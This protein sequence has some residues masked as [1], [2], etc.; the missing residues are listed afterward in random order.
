[1]SR[2]PEESLTPKQHKA[3]YALLE[4][5]TLEAAAEDVGVSTATIKRW[6]KTEAF[7]SEFRRA[8]RR[9]L[10]D[11]YAK[12]Q[13]AASEAVDTLVAHM[14]SGV[15]HLEVKAALGV[16]DRAQRGLEAYDLVERLERLEE[17]LE[18]SQAHKGRYGY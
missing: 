10:E 17:A 14:H 2:D 9:V 5:P 4:Q 3:I 16:L 6:R 18:A 15:P 13:G 7:T 11:A 1:M 8:R 12:L